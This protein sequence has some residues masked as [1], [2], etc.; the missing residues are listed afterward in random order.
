M[1]RT[2]ALAAFLLLG[3][4]CETSGGGPGQSAGTVP[5][6]DGAPAYGLPQNAVTLVNLHPDEERKQLYSVNYQQLGLISRCTPVHID[7]TSSHGIK[8]TVVS[9]GRQYD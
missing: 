6:S 3:L 1:R 5:P 4:A 8:F 2:H 7:A 9:S